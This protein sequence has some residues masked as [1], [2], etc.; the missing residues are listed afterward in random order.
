M[1]ASVDRG[2]LRTNRV[3]YH[4]LFLVF[5]LINEDIVCNKVSTLLSGHRNNL[6]GLSILPVLFSISRC[7][8]LFVRTIRV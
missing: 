7:V 6:S 3:F 1:C 4:I 8:C 5:I 2:V